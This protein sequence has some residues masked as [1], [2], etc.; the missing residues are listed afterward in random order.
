ME[1]RKLLGIASRAAEEFV[2][3]EDAAT[4]AAYKLQETEWGSTIGGW[5]KGEMPE[6][7]LA[8]GMR[9]LAHEV[10]LHG[11]RPGES[12]PQR[13][14]LGKLECTFSKAADGSIQ[15]K[16]P[17]G[18]VLYAALGFKKADVEEFVRRELKGRDE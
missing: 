13:V 18:E 2:S 3:A 15:L 1:W 8:R 12:E 6:R 7:E 16:T 4:W 14:D 9:L 5:T 11:V 17:K 10:P